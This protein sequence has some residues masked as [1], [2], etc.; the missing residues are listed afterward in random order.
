MCTSSDCNSCRRAS[1]CWRS[2]RSRMKPVKKRCVAGFHLADGKLHRK[3]RAVLALA[4]DDAADADDAPLAGDLVAIEIA[5]VA[6]AVRLRHQHADVEPGRLG[7][8]DAEQAFGGAAE[9]LN[10]AEFVDHDH[11]VR[12]GI[13][14]RLQMRLARTRVAGHQVGAAAAAV[15][16]LAAP[17]HAHADEGERQPVGH[18]GLDQRFLGEHEIGGD[19]A[20]DG[21]QQ[22]WTEAAD[23]G[24][25]QNR[26]HEIEKNRVLRHKRRQQCPHRQRQHHRDRSDSVTQD[27]AA[28]GCGRNVSFF[29]SFR[30]APARQTFLHRWRRAPRRLRYIPYGDYLNFG[31]FAAA[32]PLNHRIKEG[33]AHHAHTDRQPYCRSAENDPASR[34]RARLS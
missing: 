11:R 2:V 10:D 16:Q 6:A 15:Q 26:R 24:R 22:A 29:N 25:D 1:V 3:G 12:N 17:G 31:L 14:D 30:H 19:D 32:L 18:E 4:D 28:F 33:P 27:L 20:Q 34:L 8:A 9:G 23:R 13:E 21:R 7:G 5:V